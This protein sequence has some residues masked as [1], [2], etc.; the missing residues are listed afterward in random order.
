[1]VII[2]SHFG[3]KLLLLIFLAFL[4]GCFLGGRYV[5]KNY[6]ISMQEEISQ[7]TN[8]VEETEK[9]NSVK[10]TSPPNEEIKISNIYVVE[11]VGDNYVEVR[12]KLLKNKYVCPIL[13]KV[14]LSKNQYIYLISIKGKKYL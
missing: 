11:K 1:M 8:F 13:Q 7:Q 10:Q 5:I 9:T 4:L 12:T 2:K 3:L 6:E 14:E